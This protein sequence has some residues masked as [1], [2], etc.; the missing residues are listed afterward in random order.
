VFDF[1]EGDE[2][3]GTATGVD[4]FFFG[5]SLLPVWAKDGRLRIGSLFDYR[6]LIRIA[7]QIYSRGSLYMEVEDHLKGVRCGVNPRHVS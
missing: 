5:I 7:C 3:A 1:D 4:F 2:A 6:Q